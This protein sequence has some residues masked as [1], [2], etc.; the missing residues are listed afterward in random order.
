VRLRYDG[1]VSE[2]FQSSPYRNVRF[3]D[4]TAQ[5]GGRQITF[6]NT[7]GSVDGMPERMPESRISHAAVLEWVHSIVPGIGIH[8]E[9]RASHDTWGINSVSAAIDLRIAK[10]TW[11]MGL[12]YRYY[13]QTGAD[14]FEDKYTLAPS[15]YTYYSSDKELGD[16]RGHLV[17]LDLSRV[18]IDAKTPNDARLLLNLQVDLAHYDYPGFTLQPSRDSVFTSIGLSWE[19]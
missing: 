4:W 9:L 14:F 1:K 17:R 18:L 8:P 2:G 15:M 12:G 11:R 6:M 3:G 13:Y 19:R 5:L 16:Q 10:P 7:I